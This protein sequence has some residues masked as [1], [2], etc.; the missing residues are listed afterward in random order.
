MPKPINPDRR[1]FLGSAAI[2]LAA[3]PFAMSGPLLAQSDDAKP[4][5]GIWPVSKGPYST[6]M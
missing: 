5:A 4:G 6:P 2:A 1:R 3:A